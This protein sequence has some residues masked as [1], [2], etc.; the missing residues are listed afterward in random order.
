MQYLFEEHFY[1]WR[2][3]EDVGGDT[4]RFDVIAK[5]KGTDVF[6]R[7]LIE[8]F[9]SRYVIFEF[10]NYEKPLK[11][12]LIHVTEKYLFPRAL[13]ASAI[14]V[15]PAGLTEAAEKAAQGALRD[16]GKL[17]LSIDRETLCLMLEEK[18]QGTSPGVRMEAILDGVL[19]QLGR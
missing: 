5:V 3:Q 9:Y 13:R 12:N 7:M 14:I 4:S 18:D 16:A 8:H 19:Q 10:K 11:S 15:S 2:D 17:M 1:N 6:S